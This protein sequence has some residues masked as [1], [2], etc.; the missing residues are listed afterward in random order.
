M[1]EQSHDLAVGV[2]HPAG[3]LPHAL[4]SIL[5]SDQNQTAHAAFMS[6]TIPGTVVR[7]PVAE[8]GRLNENPKGIGLLALIREDFETHDRLWF[9]QGLW[10]IVVHRFG[11]W[12]MGIRPRILRMPFS[13]SYAV[14]YKLVEWLCG[15]SLPYTVLLGRR[16]RIWHHGGMILHAEAIGDDVHIRH[17]TTFGVARIHQNEELP[18]IGNRVDIGCGA[19]VLGKVRVGDDAVIGANA[20]VIHDV[21]AGAVVAGVP[22]RVV[23]GVPKVGETRSKADGE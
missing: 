7:P 23:R 11:N 19:C 20:V 13:L 8:R 5:S 15:I 14:L 17:N 2:R 16:V 22:A 6:E 1:G 4:T 18:V 3:P 21:P 10:A 12:R 9:E